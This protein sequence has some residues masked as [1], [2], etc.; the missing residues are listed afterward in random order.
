MTEQI[1]PID[2][3]ALQFEPDPMPN[4]RASEN[5]EETE[6]PAPSTGTGGFRGFASRS[7]RKPR[8][9][10][11]TK[12][13]VPL[14]IQSIPN[15]KGQF[16][17]PLMKMYGMAGATVMMY[18]PICGTAI[19]TS[20]QKCAETMDELAYQNESVRRVIW[21]L[22]RS[23]TFGAVI[24]AHLPILMAVIMH[25]VPAAQEAFGAMGANMMEEFL[26]Q[27][28]PDVPND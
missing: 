10:K 5:V 7:A 8:V 16:V 17:E 11:E 2:P 9:K 27:S 13:T 26:K 24:V 15:R 25:P 6:P 19:M 14:A 22:T 1:E 20:A 23:S 3:S 4:F 21:S 12:A 18:D 28:T